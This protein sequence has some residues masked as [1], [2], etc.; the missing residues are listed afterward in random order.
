MKTKSFYDQMSRTE[1]YRIKNRKDLVDR[2]GLKKVAAFDDRFLLVLKELEGFIDG[3]TGNEKIKILDTAC[4]D[5][6]YESLLAKQRREKVDFY[7]VDI[8]S[9]QLGKAKRLFRSLRQVDLDSQPLPFEDNFFD[10]VICSEILEHLFYPE[11]LLSEIKRV[12]KKKGIVLVTVPNLGSFQI[13]FGIFFSGFS[14]MVNYS[15]NK[16]HI[17]FFSAKDMFN[18]FEEAGL[19]CI[20]WHGAG[21]L[22][23]A[24][25]NIGFNL[26]MPRMF[27]MIAN[28]YGKR[29]ANGLLFILRK[30]K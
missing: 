22:L 25:W 19:D 21:S 30:R 13:R 29:F 20:R 26:P 12:L 24:K 4:G 18:L 16:P 5:G 8:S 10:Y 2:W 15:L 11:K 23:F 27:Q 1:G 7:G 14:P 17:R 9:K 28:K 3:F 6:V